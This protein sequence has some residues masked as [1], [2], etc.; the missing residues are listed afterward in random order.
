MYNYDTVTN[1]GKLIDSNGKESY[2]DVYGEI[3][4]SNIDSLNIKEL[5]EVRND[6]QKKKSRLISKKEKPSTFYLLTLGATAVIHGINTILFGTEPSTLVTLF[7]YEISF[8]NA[9]SLGILSIC[10]PA[11]VIMH[12]FANKKNKKIDIEIENVS[13]ELNRVKFK[14]S[15]LSKNKNKKRNVTFKYGNGKSDVIDATVENDINRTLE[16]R[17]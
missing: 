10:L 6:L 17:R 15:E 14:L 4:L 8:P 13:C 3:D 2:S 7:P 16:F 5:K 1:N 9:V 11:S 12:I